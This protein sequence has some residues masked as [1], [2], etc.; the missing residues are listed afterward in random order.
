MFALAVSVSLSGQTYH[1]IHDFNMAAGDGAAPDAGLL[2]DSHGN[3]FG[4]TFAGGALGGCNGYTCGTVFEMSPTGGGGWTETVIHNSTAVDAHSGAP[5]IMDAH[6]NLYGTAGGFN[7]YGSVFELLAAPNGTWIEQILHQFTGNGDGSGPGSGLTL[8]SSGVVYGTTFSGGEY[9]EGTVYSVNPRSVSN[10]KIIHSFVPSVV[11]GNSPSSTFLQIIDGHIYG[12]T[13]YGGP[14]GIPYGNGTVFD[15]TLTANGWTASTLYVFKG[16]Q[17]GDGAHPVAG[18]FDGIN[19][20]Y[21]TTQL[22]GTGTGYC[23]PYGC[24]TVYRLT[25]NSDGSW[26][27]TVLHAFQAGLDGDG[28]WGNLIFDRS[29]NIY[30]TTYAG[31]VQNEYGNGTIFKLSPSS[32][33]QWTY[34]VLVRLPGGAGGSI[35]DGG[36]VIDNAGNLYGTAQNGGAYGDGVVFE[37]TP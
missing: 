27:E 10:E 37:I 24:G 36:L 25:H 15:L 1:V 16:A 33:G 28:P 23:Q 5:L 13:V 31:G 2:L 11:S 4:T 30:G 12:T 21:G 34:S 18:L 6:G 3:L 8:D 26:S 9:N 20:F 29:G 32:G 19:N 14:N 35:I 7:S 22:G 17:H